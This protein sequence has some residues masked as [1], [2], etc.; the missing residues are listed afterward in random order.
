[1]GGADDLSRYRFHTGAPL[2]P[3]A[4]GERCPPLFRD[5]GLAALERYLR[6][7]LPRLAGPLT[8][9]LYMRTAAF[10]EPYTDHEDTG[11]LVFL[12][13]SSLSPWHAGI[14][15]VLVAR[16]T[17]PVEPGS[18]GYVPGGVEL[19]A[20]AARAGE[21]RGAA[22]LRE[23]LGGR[24]YD[25]RVAAERA[26]LGGLVRQL[27]ESERWA[28]PLRRLLQSGSASDRQRLRD[29]MAREGV[30]EHDLCAAFHHVPRERRAALREAL[31][32]VAEATTPRLRLRR[33]LPSAIERASAGGS[34]DHRKPAGS[35][36]RPLDTRGLAPRAPR[37]RRP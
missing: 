30:T 7:A 9:L 21:M 37:A 4:D 3:L 20:V 27:A 11:R 15:G 17:R 19:A 8:P 16:A 28:E 25:E 26:R 22:D 36:G 1:M 34:R 12:R 10:R 13:P 18:V 24:R 31:P 32:R 2:R 14:E 23:E 33:S 5:L 29:A 35:R 6:G